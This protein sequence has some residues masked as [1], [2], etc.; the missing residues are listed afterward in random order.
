[1]R[2]RLFCHFRR[3]RSQCQAHRHWQEPVCSSRQLRGRRRWR[4]SRRAALCRRGSPAFWSRPGA[5]ARS[6][7]S[8]RAR[9]PGRARTRLDA[10][11]SPSTASSTPTT[12]SSFSSAK[13][14]VDFFVSKVF[15]I[16]ADAPVARVSSPSRPSSIF[17][18]LPCVA[19]RDAPTSPSSLASSFARA[20]PRS[21]VPR[22]L[23]LVPLV[24]A[25]HTSA[26]AMTSISAHAREPR[27]RAILSR[28]RPRI[29]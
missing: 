24:P 6:R 15:S 16:I 3:Q 14:V 27:P 23:V 9:L 28:A 11:T 13:L 29:L 22:G 19:N 26:I 18:P 17:I 25:A 4:A 2:R 5:S 10:R 1:M 21:V 20:Y 7:S 12:S 8:P